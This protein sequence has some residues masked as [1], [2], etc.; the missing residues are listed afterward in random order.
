MR[1]IWII[2]FPLISVVALAVDAALRTALTLWVAA[3][4]E[5]KNSSTGSLRLF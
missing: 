5:I 3:D 4:S 2:E 1:E